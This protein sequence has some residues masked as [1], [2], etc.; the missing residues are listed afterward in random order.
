MDELDLS[1]AWARANMPLTEREIAALDSLSGVRLACSVH[2]EEKSVPFLEALLDRGAQVFLTT[3]NPYTVRDVVVKRLA[4]HG[5]KTHAWKGMMEEDQAKATRAALAWGPTHLYEMGATLVGQL[6]SAKGAAEGSIEAGLEATGSGISRIGDLMREGHSL[7]F[8][9]FNCD[10]VPIKEGLHNRHLV[11]LSTW[12]TF[13]E[14]TRLSLHGRHVVVVGFGL[15]GQGVAEVAR[16]FGGAVSVA[17][18]DGVRALFAEY[19]GYRVGTVEELIPEAD[20]VV[21][22]TGRPGVL[23]ARLF[24]SLKQG[25]FLLNVGHT[26]DEID[27]NALGPRKEVVPF[28]EEVSPSGRSVFLFAG[29]SMANLTAGYGDSLNSFDV[30]MATLA[31]GVR[32]LFSAE[33]GRFPP[34]LHALPRSAWVHVAQ[35]ASGV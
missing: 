30:T 11:G 15:V 10:D 21:T 28:V 14:R 34:G 17:E 3:C 29:G 5:A 22:A 19:A 18:K 6:L 12:H 13:M 16:A 26:P 24:P 35:R 32:F 20:V 33:A 23:G 7:A 1:V 4:A 8:P 31:A 2:I 27:V 25:C 9:V